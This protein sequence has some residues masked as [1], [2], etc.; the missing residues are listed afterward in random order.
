MWRSDGTEAGTI[1]LTNDLNTP[2]SFHPK[3]LT[4]ANDVLYFTNE[5]TLWKSDGTSSGTTLLKKFGEFND[6]SSIHFNLRDLINVNGSLFF[7]VDASL[8]TSDGTPDG[9]RLLENIPFGYPTGNNYFN[10]INVNETLFFTDYSGTLF[11][12]DG[13]VDGSSQVKRFPSINYQFK[14]SIASGKTHLLNFTGV[15]ENLFFTIETD[16]GLELWKSDGTEHG[17]NLVKDINP[18]ENGS[19]PQNLTNVNGQLFFTADDGVHGSELWK[20]DGT[21]SGTVLVKDILPDAGITSIFHS[22]QLTDINGLLYFFV[23]DGHYLDQL[24]K[25][26]G[27]LTGTELIIDIPKASLY[28]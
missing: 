12:T 2:I 1:Q 19:N 17:T 4:S 8:G 5:K 26:D 20:S 28:I 23:Y 10:L 24:W 11:K 27:T 9:T 6:G 21:E 15:K 7:M 13:T 25:S 18:G 3:E 14:F 22:N 16:L